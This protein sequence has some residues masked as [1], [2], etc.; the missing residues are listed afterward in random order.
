MKSKIGRSKCKSLPKIYR[1][2][3]YTLAI[4]F[5]IYII[6]KTIQTQRNKTIEGFKKHGTGAKKSKEDKINKKEGHKNRKEGHKNRKEGNRNKN[7]D[8]ES[9]DDDEEYDDDKETGLFD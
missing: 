4:G 9:S 1:Y 7:D 6:T 3:G 8:N 5:A 2:I